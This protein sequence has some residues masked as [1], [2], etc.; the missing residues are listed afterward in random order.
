MAQ[1]LAPLKLPSKR[2]AT[3]SS[4]ENSAFGMPHRRLVS[5][6]VPT[7]AELQSR[8]ALFPSSIIKRGG[9]GANFVKV[10]LDRRKRFLS[11]RSRFRKRRFWEGNDG[12]DD[13]GL[14]GSLLHHFMQEKRRENHIDKK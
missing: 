13:A 14:V 3:L 6:T 9:D 1:T 5:E 12:H 4:L 8:T 10:N 7:H 11:R 2:A